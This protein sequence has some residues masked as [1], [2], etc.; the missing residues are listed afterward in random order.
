L[1][2]SAGLPIRIKDDF[3]LDFGGELLNAGSEARYFS[4][5]RNFLKDPSSAYWRKD[6]YHIYRDV[7]LREHKEAL[8]AANLQYDVTVIP[9]G[10]IGIEFVKTIGHYHNSKQRTNIAYPEVYEVVYGRAFWLLQSASEDFERLEEVYL[11]TASKGEKAVFPPGFGHVTI[12]PTDDILVVANWKSRDCRGIYE[13][14]EIHNGAAYYIC[15]SQKLLA[16]GSTAE[17]MD[18]LPNLAYKQ[19]PELLKVG[20]RELSQYDLLTALPSYF[21]ATKNLASIDFLNNPENYLDDL[22]PEKLFK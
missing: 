11:V 3:L 6:A 7:C 13:P 5:M 12:N 14:Y 1:E 21:T 15:E 16:S 10:R 22:I 18:F 9:P 8:A 19:V 20:P 2:K 4:S 17:D